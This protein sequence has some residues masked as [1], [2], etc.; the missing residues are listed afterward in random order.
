MK[1]GVF[2]Q[3][4]NFWGAKLIHIPLFYSIRNRYPEAKITALCPYKE[5]QFFTNQSLADESLYYPKKF[6]VVYRLLKEKK[7]DLIFCLRPECV[8]LNMVLAF[9]F[10]REKIGFVHAFSRLCYTTAIP[11]N[12]KIYRALLFKQL[13]DEDRDLS[14]YFK[15]YPAKCLPSRNNIFILPGGG[16]GEFKRWKIENFLSV[17]RLISYR[18]CTFYF[19]LGEQEG[20][21]LPIVKNFA[22][23]YPSE[24]LYLK[25][26][27]ELCSYFQSGDLFI[28]NDCGAMHLAQM[29]AKPV[30]FILSDEQNLGKKIAGEW[31]LPGPRSRLIMSEPGQN[32]NSIR[33][34]IVFK[35]ALELLSAS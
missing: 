26:L 11:Y 31:F 21:Y 14:G 29:L 12:K 18:D 24:I 15:Q 1:I 16:A 5:H 4:R 6:F 9:I 22:D 2:V 20:S 19:V 30:V 7:F 33:P 17:C 28:G 13:I 3:N 25:N 10:S 35:I 34:E 27:P 8:W 32:I 23:S